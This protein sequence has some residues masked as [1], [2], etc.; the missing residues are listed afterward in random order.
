[1]FVCVCVR[2]G[3]WVGGWAGRYVAVVVGVFLCAPR[4]L[5][6]MRDPR[7]P[8][9]P[10]PL[11]C[12]DWWQVETSR[13]FLCDVTRVS[14]AALLLFG[15]TPAEL[16]VGRAKECGRAELAGGVRVSAPAQV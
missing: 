6:P 16:D 15:A 4:T 13:L 1:M 10:H 11:G 9:H 7:Q 5:G 12:C 3:G 14:P 8:R 2:V